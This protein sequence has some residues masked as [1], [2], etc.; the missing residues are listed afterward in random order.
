MGICKSQKSR[1]PSFFW[2]PDHEIPWL[3]SKAH[4]DIVINEW[5]SE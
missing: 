1:L 4:K 2:F 3:S 5:V